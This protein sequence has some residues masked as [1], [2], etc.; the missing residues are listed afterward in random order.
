AEFRIDA[1]DLR[2]LRSIGID[3]TRKRRARGTR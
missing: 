2:F 1:A 3:P